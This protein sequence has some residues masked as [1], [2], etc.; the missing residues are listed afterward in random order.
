[1]AAI[2][3]ASMG[4]TAYADTG[5]KNSA[6][7]VI[8]LQAFVPVICRVRLNTDVGSPD[9]QGLVAL[10][11]AHEFCNA[12]SGYRVMIQHPQDLQGAA[13]I[14]D[15]ERIPLS[16]SGETLLTDSPHADLRT[17]RLSADMGDEPNR[18][19]SLSVR[20]EPRG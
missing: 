7:S 16:A 8:R 1:M 20:I 19:R 15:G 13:I 6:S 17:V 9:A 3:F 11:T 10:G 12:P 4:A 14:S 2:V 5:I 18:F